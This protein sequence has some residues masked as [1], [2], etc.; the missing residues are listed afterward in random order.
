MQQNGEGQG[1]E[2]ELAENGGGRGLHPALLPAPGAGEAEPGRA[3]GQRQGQGD[4]QGAEFGN[5]CTG[6]ERAAA[7]GASSG[8]M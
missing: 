6:P 3:G 5:H 8:G 7:K 1:R 2:D 4:A